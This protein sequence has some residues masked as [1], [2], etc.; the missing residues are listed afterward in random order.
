M[1]TIW[2]KPAI[3]DHLIAYWLLLVA[4]L[5]FDGAIP[6]YLMATDGGLSLQEDQISNVLFSAGIV[7]GIFHYITYH[8]ITSKFSLYKALVITSICGVPVS[9]FIPFASILNRG[10][11]E[12]SLSIP[13]LLFMAIIIGSTV[14]FAIAY[15]SLSSVGANRSV[16][17]EELSVMNG[18]SMMGGSI[19]QG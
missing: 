7:F 10:A 2:T 16:K 6:L 1:A 11:P 9:I 15:Y 13:A 4:L 18:V 12:G 19:A 17:P 3:R 5:F 8:K 14:I